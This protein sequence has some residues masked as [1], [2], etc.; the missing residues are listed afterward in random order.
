MILY[1]N[2]AT[3]APVYLFP[4]KNEYQIKNTLQI[5][6]NKIGTN[7]KPILTNEMIAASNKILTNKSSNCSIINSQRDFP[8]NKGEIII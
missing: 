7:R 2:I 1:Q 3:L 8:T 6:L 5:I 4:Q